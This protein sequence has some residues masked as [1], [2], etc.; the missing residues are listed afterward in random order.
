MT[1]RRLRDNENQIKQI[2]SAIQDLCC[3]I[4][5]PDYKDSE[6]PLEA[7]KWFQ[8]KLQMIHSDMRDIK[9]Y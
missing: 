4:Q 5:L 6:D 9:D 7:Q 8:N 1:N 3:M 2:A